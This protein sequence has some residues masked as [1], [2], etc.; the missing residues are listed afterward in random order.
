MQMQSRALTRS[1]YITNIASACSISRCGSGDS[2][3]ADYGQQCNNSDPILPSATSAA[4]HPPDNQSV[5]TLDGRNNISQNSTPALE[6]LRP[7]SNNDD[8]D[9]PV[10]EAADPRPTTTPIPF[11]VL[12]IIGLLALFWCAS[13]EQVIITASI[14]WPV[15]R[16][17]FWKEI[18]ITEKCEFSKKEQKGGIWLTY[19][20]YLL[21]HTIRRRPKRPSNPENL[22]IMST[23]GLADTAARDFKLSRAHTQIRT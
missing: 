4:L 15:S 3:N 1:N 18:T 12:A 22:D 23:V 9:A 16:G 8:D 2:G 5:Y 11:P 10:P 17:D 20:P 13:W 19:A 21:Q 14:A 6:S 7:P